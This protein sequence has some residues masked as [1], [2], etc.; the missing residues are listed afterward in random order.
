[1]NA[2]AACFKKTAVFT[3]GVLEN[4][5]QVLLGQSSKSLPPLFMRSVLLALQAHPKMKRKYYFGAG[6]L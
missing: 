6:A 2:T 5:L 4:V 1:M 3:Q